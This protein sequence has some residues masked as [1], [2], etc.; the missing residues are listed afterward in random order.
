M[1]PNRITIN[2]DK[3]GR[4]AEKETVTFLGVET[5]PVERTLSAQ[6]GL[7]RDV[8][9]VVHHV[10]DDSPASGV[11]M[12]NDVLTKFEDQIL[13]DSRQ[14]S[15]LIR[16]HKSGDEV[17]LTLIRGGKEIAP[18]VKLGQR[19]VRLAESPRF[20]GG[21][22][23]GGMQFFS[24]GPGGELRGLDQLRQLP[25]MGRGDLDNVMRMISRERGNLLGG[26]RL[27]VLKHGAKGSTILDLPKSNFVY[28]D[29]DGTVELKSEGDKRQLTVKDAKGKV[30]FNGPVDTEEDRKK[31]PADVM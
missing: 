26:P 1:D 20:F 22:G 15:V 31:I 9:L 12:E 5:G 14:L 6:L 17:T 29:D 11:L 18:K 23:D 30:T 13:V 25:G 2:I 7:A 16:A 8:G 27:R 4:H 28:S 10:A 19:D 3:D 24:F 21:G